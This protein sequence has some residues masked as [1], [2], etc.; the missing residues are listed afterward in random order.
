MSSDLITVNKIPKI[1]NELWVRLRI[2]MKENGRKCIGWCYIPGDYDYLYERKPK[3]FKPLRPAVD[4]HI[5][6]RNWLPI[7]THYGEHAPIVEVNAH[8]IK[9]YVITNRVFMV[10]V[11]VWEAEDKA[12][13]ERYQVMRGEKNGD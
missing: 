2:N 12:Q 10:P 5:A 1:P 8:Y 9:S 11:E 7:Y 13:Y 6:N 3:S 4:L